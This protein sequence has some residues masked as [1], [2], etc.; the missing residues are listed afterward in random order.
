MSHLPG[1]FVWFE[2]A[3][4]DIAKARA[5]YEPLFGWHTESM[6]MGKQRYQMILNRQVGIGG[7]STAPAGTPSRWMCYLSVPDVDAT[8]AAALAA[9]ARSLMAPT[10][11]G[12][13]GRGAT[14]ADPTGAILSLWKSAEGDRADPVT[15]A[16]GDWYWNE[17]WTSD[18]HKAISFYERVFGYSHESMDMG[19][20]GTYHLLKRDGVSRAGLMRSTQPKAPSMWLPYVAVDDCDAMASKVKVLGAQIVHNPQQVEGVGRFAVLVDPLGAAL[21]IMKPAPG[22][23]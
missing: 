15:T 9:G 12:P 17:L 6:A 5:F 21:A 18:E 1:K 11:F 13:I 10:D 14:I 3:S 19:P 22:A 16:T 4:N 23:A 8:H 7:Y 2:H 20:E